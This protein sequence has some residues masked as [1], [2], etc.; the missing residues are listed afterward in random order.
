M[1]KRLFATVLATMVVLAVA[2]LALATTHHGGSS[3]KSA[4]AAKTA[5]GK[6]FLC[7]GSVVSVDPTAG[8][9]LVT[10]AKGS[11]VM[12]HYVG[13]QV[14]FTLSKHAR[15]L[16]RTADG[17]Q[18]AY[19]PVTLDQVTPGSSVHINGRLGHDALGAP[20]FYARLVKVVLAAVVAPAP[21][22]D[23]SAS[24]TVA[25]SASPS[26]SPSDAPAS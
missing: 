13:T 23:P 8:T 6:P 16:A 7:K 5:K 12:R 9:L 10:V 20:V 21:T 18:T 4:K 26:A 11:H 1:K 14:A 15:I 24:P 22:A 3:A 17:S 2:P 19:A 25:P